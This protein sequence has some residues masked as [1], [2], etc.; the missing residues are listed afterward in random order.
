M[1]AVRDWDKIL[2]TMSSGEDSDA[3]DDLNVM[4]VQKNAHRVAELMHMSVPGL[5][6]SEA[7][8]PPMGMQNM[9]ATSAMKEGLADAIAAS[10]KA[11]PVPPP[12]TRMQNMDAA[13]ATAASATAASATA[14][15]VTAESSEAKPVSP[16]P[17]KETKRRR[18]TR[19][20]STA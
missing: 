10:S 20:K 2:S 17:A 3:Y 15:S 18:S 1:R 9:D 11:K 16:P 5:D 19:L 6:T 13:S 8:T 7:R 14:A 12:L 4:S